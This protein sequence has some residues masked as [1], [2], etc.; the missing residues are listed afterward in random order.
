LNEEFKRIA[1]YVQT[2]VFDERSLE[3]AL[4]LRNILPVVWIACGNQ[5]GIPDKALPEGI[6]LYVGEDSPFDRIISFNEKVKPHSILRVPAGCPTILITHD[7][8]KEMIDIFDKEDAD[9]CYKD[10]RPDRIFLEITHGRALSLLQEK[11][12]ELTRCARYYTSFFHNPGLFKVVSAA[13]P[14]IREMQKEVD[15]SRWFHSIDFGN[16]VKSYGYSPNEILSPQFELLDCFKGKRVLDVGM[17]D[18]YYSFIVEKKGAREVVGVDIDSSE[19]MDIGLGESRKIYE[20]QIRKISPGGESVPNELAKNFEI[21]KRLF[22]SSV[23]RVGMTAY[24]ISPEKL[25]MF[26][27]VLYLG[28]LYHLL[29][30]MLGLARARSVCKGEMFLQTTMDI[31]TS[32]KPIMSFTEGGIDVSGPNSLD[33][34]HWWTPNL[35][36]LKAMLRTAGFSKIEELSV[37]QRRGYAFLRCE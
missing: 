16:G 9:M 11:R 29:N 13:P 25:G 33:F 23:K 5:A 35:A 10:G 3:T 18:G 22:N 20:S 37:D 2:S 8:V 34:S 19:D 6:R 12:K 31:D 15:S 21:A 26:D 32:E 36:C 27:T 24:E 1:G 30:P 7:S 28:V 17:A 14:S 4:F